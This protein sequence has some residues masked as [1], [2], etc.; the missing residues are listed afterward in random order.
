[1][2]KI[3]KL[4]HASEWASTQAQSH[5]KGSPVDQS[6]G[7]IHFSTAAQVQET[8]AKHF[9]GIPDLVLA[10]VDPAHLGQ[11]LKWETSRGGK[12]FPHLY[13]ALPLSAVTR[14][15]NLSLCPDGRHKFPDRLGEL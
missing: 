1:V 13:A 14:I 4:F 10:E 3:Y 7:F 2:P 11:P 6:D 12:L 8:A 15:W 5:F 9:A